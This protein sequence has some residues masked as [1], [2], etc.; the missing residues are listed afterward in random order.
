MITARTNRKIRRAVV[1]LDSGSRVRLRTLLGHS[2]FELP[3]TPRVI[4]GVTSRL[5]P[6]GARLAVLSTLD[7]GIDA[8]VDIS[9]E[10]AAKGFEVIPH[11]TARSIRDDAHLGWIISQLS[12][13]R[14]STVLVVGGDGAPV[15]Q[16]SEAAGLMPALVAAGF[17]LGIAGYPE[18]HPFLEP[19][20]LT[21]SLLAKAPHAAFIATQPC[22]EPARILRWAAELRLRGCELPI[23]VGVAGVVGGDQLREMADEIGVGPSRHALPRLGAVYHPSSILTGL[24]AP[25]AFDRLNITAVRV[26]TFGDVA[27]TES[28]R[29]QLYDA[30]G[31][32]QAV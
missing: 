22:F 20:Q 30:A 28:W 10:I 13:A 27:S 5:V 15:G 3:P 11:L 24:V 18:G 1:G 8:T 9:C 32:R 4:D 16:Y 26:T 29:Q 21:Q 17:S 6:G 31:E 25:E 14:I 2:S 23:E 19:E 7:A 12:A